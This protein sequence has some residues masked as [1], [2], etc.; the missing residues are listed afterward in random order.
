[1]AEYQ[2][3][4]AQL[5]R[6]GKGKTTDSEET[7]E[8]TTP[9]AFGPSDLK[10]EGDQD[11]PETKDIPGDRQEQDE[12]PP[13]GTGGNSPDPDDDDQSDDDHPLLSQPTW[14]VLPLSS[15]VRIAL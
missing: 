15:D 10:T 13:E 8:P 3:K 1:V 6:K 12:H 14:L 7:K 4:L 11:H 5:E 2:K 9:G